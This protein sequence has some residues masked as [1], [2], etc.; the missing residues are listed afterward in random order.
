[1]MDSRAKLC[2][3]HASGEVEDVVAFGSALSHLKQRHEV[4]DVVDLE[5]V[6]QNVV[7]KNG[8]IAHLDEAD[9]KSD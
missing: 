1:M 5:G 9:N 3:F 8:I 2:L 4:E 6:I 7:I